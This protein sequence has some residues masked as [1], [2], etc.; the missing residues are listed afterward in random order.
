MRGIVVVYAVPWAIG[1]VGVSWGGG[2]CGA[3]SGGRSCVRRVESPLL[4]VLGRLQS[5]TKFSRKVLLSLVLAAD[6]MRVEAC[7]VGS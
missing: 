6:R 1:A 3:R 2:D 4:L 5:E 7:D